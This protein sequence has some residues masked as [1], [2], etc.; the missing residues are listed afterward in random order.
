M[1]NNLMINHDIKIKQLLV[2]YIQLYH[3]IQVIHCVNMMTNQNLLIYM[4]HLHV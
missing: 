3:I 2:A 4:F 1:T